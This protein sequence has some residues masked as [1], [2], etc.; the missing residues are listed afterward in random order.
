M[1]P[2]QLPSVADLLVSLDRARVI[3]SLWNDERGV[4]LTAISDL[5]KIQH[6]LIDLAPP[7]AEGKTVE[8]SSPAIR[9]VR[10]IALAYTAALAQ[11]GLK[12]VP[13]T[14]DPG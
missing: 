6:E 1:S 11:S 12:I 9:Q 8:L 14:G 2:D 10:A 3:A 4:L 13:P 7:L 5:I